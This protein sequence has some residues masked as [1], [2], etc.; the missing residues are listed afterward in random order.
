MTVLL[1]IGQIMNIVFVHIVLFIV[2]YVLTINKLLHNN[3]YCA[4]C[5]TFSS[6]QN[7]VVFHVI[8]INLH[9][10]MGFVL[11]V[12]FLVKHVYLKINA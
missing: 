12:F 8:K 5:H 6:Q 9:L 4:S 11:P 7:L 3:A 1:V 2:Q 10:L